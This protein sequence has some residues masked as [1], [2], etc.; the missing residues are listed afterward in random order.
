MLNSCTLLF[1]GYC[2]YSIPIKVI[3]LLFILTPKWV[4]AA[5]PVAPDCPKLAI[6]EE[7]ISADFSSVVVRNSGGSVIAN[8]RAQVGGY[9][10]YTNI[11][12]VNTGNST[13]AIDM[14]VTFVSTT[15]AADAD[16]YIEFGF[17][18][19]GARWR[20]NNWDANDIHNLTVQ[21]FVTGTSTLAT[22]SGVWNFSDLDRPVSNP[23]R[24]YM[25]TNILDNYLLSS[26]TNIT[27]ATV[28]SDYQFTGTTTATSSTDPTCAF[29]AVIENVQSFNMKLQNGGGSTS[30][31]INGDDFNY[32]PSANCTKSDQYSTTEDASVVR[33]AA[34]GALA[35][36]YDFDGDVLT[37]SQVQ[38]S[39]ANV[40]STITLP[41]GATVNMTSTGAF[42]YNPNPAFDYLAAGAIKVDS[43]YY[44]VSDGTGNFD[45]GTVTITITGVNDAPIAVSDFVSTNKGSELTL[46]TLTSNDTDIDGSV[47]PSSM[48]IFTA[49]SNGSASVSTGVVTYTPTAGFSGADF[50]VYRVCDNASPALCDTARVYVTVTNLCAAAIP[51]APPCPS[52]GSTKTLSSGAVTFNAADAGNYI[53]PGSSITSGTLTVQPG[54]GNTVNIYICSGQTMTLSGVNLNSGTLNFYILSGGML[55][56]TGNLNAG[57]Y[58]VYGTMFF[59]SNTLSIQNNASLFVSTSGIAYGGALD[60]TSTAGTSY[61]QG[62]LDVTNLTVQK[63]TAPALCMNS[64]G[65]TRTSD[66]S[67]NNTLNGIQTET[68]TGYMYF[69]NT[70]GPCSVNQNI[71]NTSALNVCSRQTSACAAP[72]KWGSASVTNNCSSPASSCIN[73]LPINLIYFKLAETLEGVLLNW[74]SSS[75]QDSD[76][77]II[78]RSTD[79]ITWARIGSLPSEFQSYKNQYYQFIDPSPLFGDNYYR[80]IEVDVKG[81]HTN[82]GIQYLQIDS[83]FNGFTLFPNPSSGELHVIIAGEMVGIYPF[84]LY[85]VTGK[86]LMRKSVVAGTNDLGVLSLAAGIYV[87]KIRIGRDYFVERLVVQ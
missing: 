7:F 85:D 62:L 51:A 82:Y 13:V 47:Q 25:P 65:C 29:S 71:S 72:S 63:S 70:T 59:N 10:T 5:P 27:V 34:T 38:G 83:H 42:T 8:G 49:P 16:G 31:F 86:I 76:H 60:L 50:F 56:M 14:R 32:I 61:I 67:T 48:T 64:S 30:F 11:G 15:D 80:L 77:F 20:A 84:E 37:V 87:A 3:L 41:S 9:A 22:Y 36:D 40:G 17:N 54:S 53:F 33:N 28:G 52:G 12:T 57:N 2:R 79:G 58:Y 66:I 6:P 74:A 35:N 78:E 75:Q 24:V 45:L 46:S 18:S 39:A 44:Q 23:E 4:L 19:N 81:K 73:P 21:F 43:F 68:G 1:Q 55:R 69:N 26:P